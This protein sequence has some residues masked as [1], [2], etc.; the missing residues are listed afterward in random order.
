MNTVTDE[1]KFLVFLKNQ[2]YMTWDEIIEEVEHYKIADT[3]V[4][5]SEYLELEYQAYLDFQIEDEMIAERYAFSNTQSPSV[6]LTSV[7]EHEVL[8]AGEAK[9]EVLSVM[10]H[11]SRQVCV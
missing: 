4:S 7:S 2:E 10:K 8:S 11:N 1:E 9:H 3:N 6:Q 5:F